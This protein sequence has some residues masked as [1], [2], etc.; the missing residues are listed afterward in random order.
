L[1]QL[2]PCWGFSV[3]FSVASQC[4]PSGNVWQDMPPLDVTIFGSEHNAGVLH[5]P[6]GDRDRIVG[7]VGLLPYHVCLLS[8]DLNGMEDVVQYGS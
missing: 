6:P 5:G 8:H 2:L 4:T 1:T 3:P 7:C